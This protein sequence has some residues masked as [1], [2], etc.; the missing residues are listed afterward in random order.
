ML[1][2]ICR[3]FRDH[4]NYNH[5]K[6]EHIEQLKTKKEKK[7]RHTRN[8]RI[9]DS[10]HISILDQFITIKRIVLAFFKVMLILEF[11]LSQ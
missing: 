7:K 8:Y 4:S 10:C 2:L 6:Q 9:I 5:N 11:L 1:S 3:C